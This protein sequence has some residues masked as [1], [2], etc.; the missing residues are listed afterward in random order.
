MDAKEHRMTYRVTSEWVGLKRSA[1]F[2]SIDFLHP[3]KFSVDWDNCVLVRALE[4]ACPPV[5][6][7]LE[8]EFVGKGFRKDAPDC[9][10]G[11]RLSTVPSRSLLALATPVTRKSFERATAVIYNG[12]QPWDRSLMVFFRTIAVPFAGSDGS[13]KYVLGGVS[14]KLAGEKVAPERIHTEF[15]EF[16]DGSWLPLDDDLD[17]RTFVHGIEDNCRRQLWL[18]RLSLLVR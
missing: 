11:V 5:P 4:P 3:K 7:A 18:D 15:L 1:S 6:A 2:P 14:Y 9:S 8:F 17:W 13:L 12:I 16:Q 10:A